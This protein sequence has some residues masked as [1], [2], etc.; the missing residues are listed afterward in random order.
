MFVECSSTNKTNK[1][2]RRGFQEKA[3]K[4]IQTD[5]KIQY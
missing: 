1:R 4:K 2:T 3:E 5:D